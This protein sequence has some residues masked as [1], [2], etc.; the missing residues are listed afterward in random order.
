MSVKKIE[1]IPFKDFHK[2]QIVEVWEQ[3][4]LATHHFLTSSDFLEIKEMVSQIDFNALQV[5]CLFEESKLVGFVGVA[6]EKVEMLFLHPDYIGRGYGRDL[7]DFAVRELSADKVDVNEQNTN[8]VN[9]YKKY[10]FQTYERTDK[11]DQ[12]RDYP[13]LRMQLK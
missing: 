2:P 12:N 1:I 10:G 8:A 6:D 5:Y 11:D 3:S 13:I 7:M 4:V 9:F